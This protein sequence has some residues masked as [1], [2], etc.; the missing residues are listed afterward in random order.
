MVAIL[1]RERRRGSGGREIYEVETYGLIEM[2]TPR[3]YV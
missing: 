1:K 2:H 3:M